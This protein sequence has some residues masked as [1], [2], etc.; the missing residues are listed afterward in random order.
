MILK[1]KKE[2]LFEKSLFLN[3]C[4]AENVFQE[5]QQIENTFCYNFFL[6]GVLYH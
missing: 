4:L 2:T 5:N 6:D 3:I 1:P